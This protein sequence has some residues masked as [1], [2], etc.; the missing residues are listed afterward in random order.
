MEIVDNTID[1][2]NEI[3]TSIQLD[4]DRIELLR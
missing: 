3:D 2:E 1:N 4:K